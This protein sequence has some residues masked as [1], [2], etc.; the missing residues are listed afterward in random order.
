MADF[1]SLSSPGTYHVV[2]N[3]QE[4]YP[5]TIADSVYDAL[6]KDSLR[7]FYLIRCGLAINDP[8]TG[9]NKNACHTA[10]DTIRGSALT[11][12]MSGG[13][14]NAGD[15]GKWA[16]MEAISCAYMMWLYELKT[17]RM[18]GLNNNIKES[19]NGISDLLN[20]AKWGLDWMMKLQNPDGSVYHKSDTEPNF[21]WGTKPDM[22]PFTRYVSYQA[23]SQPQA[24][25]SID[26][27]VFTA[28]MAQAARVFADILPSYSSR[29]RQAALLSW[30]WLKNNRGIGQTDPY[31]TD[32][33]TWQEEEWAMAEI[34][35][36]T[37]DTTVS[38]L[39][40]T[41]TDS[42]ALEA[43]GWPTPE[44]FGYFTLWEEPNTP[45]ALK[46]KIAS[47]IT[48]L[49]D[50]IVATAGVA[51]YGVARGA[52]DY[53]WGSNESIMHCS[54]DLL[55]GYE[56]TGNESYKDTALNQLGYILGN[57]SLNKSFVTKEGTN[58][59]SHPYNW[60][61]YD[62]NILMPGWASGGPNGYASGA[63]SDAPLISLIN[64]GTPP[65]KCWLDLAATNGSY[66]SNEGQTTENAALV[67]LSGYFYSVVY[68][69]TP[70]P[71]VTADA[72]ITATMTPSATVTMT[73]PATLTPAANFSVYPVPC[74]LTSGDAGITF[75]NLPAGCLLQV[76]N[77]NGEIVLKTKN[78]SPGGKYF[79]NLSGLSHNRS[80]A[81]GIYVYMVTLKGKVL[82]KGKTAIIR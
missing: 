80:M 31:Y 41:D 71:T 9:L 53:Y 59:A 63:G 51:G 2:V 6:F 49:C 36:L 14:H 76:Y 19:G 58:Y 5:F 15:F 33:V 32:S 29:C 24:P 70:T 37:G 56:A 39:F 26:A 43:T 67:F 48:S 61:Y 46:A 69:P 8:V 78:D 1:S 7:C 81:P 16:H 73:P 62:Y 65:A 60:V 18:S 4:S 52:A 72:V 77:L 38:S 79:W 11:R 17:A 25:S 28:A 57:N 10:P 50:S 54:N 27:G 22:D 47:R 21:C 64:L 74:N 55:M 23:M 45:P 3:G 35:R 66:A 75:L 68:P 13:W 40:D 34:F 30:N 82:Q 44:F 12:D 42:H 20:E